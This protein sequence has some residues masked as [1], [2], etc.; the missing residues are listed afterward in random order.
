MRG[1]IKNAKRRFE[2]AE[3]LNITIIVIAPSTHI[4]PCWPAVPTRCPNTQI[5]CLETTRRLLGPA[6]EFSV[7]PSFSKHNKRKSFFSYSILLLQ[8]SSNLDSKKMTIH[9]EFASIFV[10]EEV[11]VVTDHECLQRFHIIVFLREKCN[12]LIH[13][14]WNSI[15]SYRWILQ[16]VQIK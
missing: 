4:S 1:I 9:Q 10:R 16:N 7:L 8:W 2:N 3:Q 6:S 13:W 5:R 12:H 15:L 11:D 14:L